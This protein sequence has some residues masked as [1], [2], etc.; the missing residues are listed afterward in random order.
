MRKSAVLIAIVGAILLIA[1]LVLQRSDELPGRPTVATFEECA[2]ADYPVMESY[3]RQCRAEGRTFVEDIGTTIEK[4]NLIR[5]SSPRPNETVSSPLAVV[6]EA[7]G[8]WFFEA[9]FPIGLLDANGKELVTATATAQG[10][11]MTENFVPFT[12]TLTFPVPETRTGTLVLKKENASGLPEHDDELR[13]PIS[14]R[15]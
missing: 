14:F 6:G 9:S 8:T 5:L 3:P 4:Q 13:I 12:A 10:D 11:W 1:V 15:D 7:R 2:R